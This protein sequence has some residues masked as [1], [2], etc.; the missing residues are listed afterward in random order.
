MPDFLIKDINLK[1]RSR[2]LDEDWVE[3]LADLIEQSGLINPIRLWKDDEGKAWLVAGNHRMAAHLLL[4]TPSLSSLNA[5]L[6][7]SIY[8]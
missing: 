4:T 1:D 2:E 3:V 8:C 5:G 7:C 6:G